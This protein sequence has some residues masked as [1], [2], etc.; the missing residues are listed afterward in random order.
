MRRKEYDMSLEDV[1]LSRGRNKNHTSGKPTVCETNGDVQNECGWGGGAGK[2]FLSGH[3]T[4]REKTDENHKQR[5]PKHLHETHTEN[6][7]STRT[8]GKVL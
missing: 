2:S 6:T 5:E 3:R 4:H 8:D 7:Q 1:G